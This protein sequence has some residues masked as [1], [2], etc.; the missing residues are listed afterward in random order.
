MSV[1]G[2][3][4]SMHDQGSSLTSTLSQLVPLVLG[5]GVAVVISLAE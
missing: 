2:V 4:P 3:M 1:G 5:M